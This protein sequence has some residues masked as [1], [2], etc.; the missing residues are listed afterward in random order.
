MAAL[1]LYKS[2]REEWEEIMGKK[3]SK[4]NEIQAEE[5]N[6]QK[7]VARQQ[8]QYY[9]EWLR[10]QQQQQAAYQGMPSQEHFLWQQQYW[11]NG[12]MHSDW[13]MCQVQ[14]YRIRE[15]IIVHTK[16]A[17]VTSLTQTSPLKAGFGITGE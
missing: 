4:T 7:K 13:K 3:V 6:Y 8:K 12:V 15:D 16:K 2:V 9:H 17:I 10:Y 5:R 14:F 1:E 11:T